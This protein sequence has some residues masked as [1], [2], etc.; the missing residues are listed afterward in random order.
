MLSAKSF[1]YSASKASEMH[2]VISV[3]RQYKELKKD[4]EKNN[5]ELSQTKKNINSF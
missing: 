3:K 4:Y 1:N 2:L 5:Q